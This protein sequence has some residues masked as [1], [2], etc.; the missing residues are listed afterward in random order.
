MT[1]SNAVLLYL[2]NT[3]WTVLY[4]KQWKQKSSYVSTRTDVCPLNKK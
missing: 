3:N 4:S 1:E 2:T